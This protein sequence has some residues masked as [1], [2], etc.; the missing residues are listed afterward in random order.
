MKTIIFLLTLTFLF[1]CG[2]SQQEAKNETKDQQNHIK[3]SPS[4]INSLGIE[5]GKITNEP[6]ALR[7]YASGMI[8]VPPQNK[9]YIAIPFGGF[10]KR[11]EVL[12]GMR[13]KKGQL[14]MVVEHAEIIALQQEFLELIGQNEF[15]EL[16]YTRQKELFDNESGSAKNYQ[17]A[18]SAYMVN[19]AKLNGLELKLEMANVNLTQLR[20]GQIERSQ[21]I[22]SPFDGVITK[23]TANVGAFA[24]PKDNLM[25]IIDLQHAHAELTIFEKYLAYLKVGQDVKVNFIDS[26]SSRQAKV[27]VIGQDISPERTFK[28]HCHFEEMPN[29][30]IPGSFLN[31][32]ISTLEHQMHTLPQEAIVEQEGKHIVFIAEGN[33]FYQVEV[34]V[35]MTQDGKIAIESN[36]MN[37]LLHSQIVTKGAYELLAIL[38]KEIE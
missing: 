15:L 13:V 11:I 22:L 9:S 12:D 3:L 21:R 5:L 30:I 19:K 35:L 29:Q 25:E 23:V 26:S 16:E 4:Q 17:Q 18:K 2:S 24:E 1:S 14:L 33:N 6:L 10:I 36:S 31:A 34:E 38:N 20:K 32:E 27:F 37:R 28:V 7:I 8:D